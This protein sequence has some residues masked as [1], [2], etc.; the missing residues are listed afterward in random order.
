M[1]NG[2][3]VLIDGIESAPVEIQEK[4]SSLFG[5][6]PEINLY[7]CGQGFFFTRDD[8]FPQENQIHPDFHLF[9]TY[10]PNENNQKINKT[11]ISKASTFTLPQIDESIRNSAQLLFCSLTKQQNNYPNYLSNE[12]ASRFAIVHE[13]CKNKCENDPNSFVWDYPYNGRTLIFLTKGFNFYRESVLN[14]LSENIYLPIVF[15]LNCFYSKSFTDEEKMNQFKLELVEKFKQ[16]PPK[17]LIDNLKEIN[18][19]IYERNMKVLLTLLGI[20]KSIREKMNVNTH[21]LN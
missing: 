16:Q 4:I 7:E 21:Y 19:N 1:K 12:I 17:E 9:V 5:D 14:S 15:G 20:Q 3:F 6:K 8:S 11:L 2:Y 13:T 10:N 18:A